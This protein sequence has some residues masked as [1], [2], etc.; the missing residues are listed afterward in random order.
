MPQTIGTPMR[1]TL[2]L[3]LGVGLTALSGCVV[4]PVPVPAEA[5]RDLPFVVKVP[6]GPSGQSATR[7]AGPVPAETC[8]RVS[9]AQE[10]ALLAEINA[11]RKQN[12]LPTLRKSSRIGAV[13]QNHACD[14]ARR[15]TVSHTSSNGKS[16]S[17]R[18]KAGGYYLRVAAENTGLGFSGDP[19]RLVEYWMN[20]PGHR[21]NILNPKVTE[22]GV[23]YA[24]GNTRPAW[25]LNVAAPR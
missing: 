24:A 16:L 7:V 17:G 22:A 23:G 19:G 5:S 8:A 14:N 9:T 15:Q 18:L 12:G 4:V 20:S 25:V 11:I 6:L 21:A 10:A 13:A 1:R 3:I 2:A